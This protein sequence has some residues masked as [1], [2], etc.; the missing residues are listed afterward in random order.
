ME[1]EGEREKDGRPRNDEAKAAGTLLRSSQRRITNTQSSI[2][3][4]IKVKGE[5]AHKPAVIMFCLRTWLPV[6]FFMFVLALP[7]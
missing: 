3:E 5:D 7:N 6:L 4:Q 2:L 1:T